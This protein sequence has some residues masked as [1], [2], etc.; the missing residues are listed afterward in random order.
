MNSDLGTF[1]NGVA[2]DS[3][4]TAGFTF[5]LVP[6]PR[7]VIVRINEVPFISDNEIITEYWFNYENGIEGGCD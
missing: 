3:L 7:N 2:S 1:G 5:D 4:D 6:A